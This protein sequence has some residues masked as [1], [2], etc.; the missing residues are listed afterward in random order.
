[1]LG[2]GGVL[3][4]K[5]SVEIPAAVPGHRQDAGRQTMEK[6]DVVAAFGQT[7]LLGPVRIKAVTWA[8]FCLV[9]TRTIR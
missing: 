1:M 3:P 9:A 4:D 2:S 5:R 8:G 7:G 6:A